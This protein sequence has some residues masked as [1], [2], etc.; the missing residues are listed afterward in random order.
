MKQNNLSIDFRLSV[1]NSNSYVFNF[2]VQHSIQTATEIMV[3][4]FDGKKSVPA[5]YIPDS[6]RLMPIGIDGY[7]TVS[8]YTLTFT[9]VSPGG[10]IEELAERVST[11][12]SALRGVSSDVEELGNEVDTINDTLPE[13]TGQVDTIVSYL[14][15][16]YM[17]RMAMGNPVIFSDGA[18][19]NFKSVSAAITYAQSGSGDPYPPGG[20]KN[21][22]RALPAS[23]VTE[24]VT[25][26]VNSNGSISTAGVSTGNAIT[27]IS[28]SYLPPGNYIV[29]G[30][31]PG[32][33]N[34]S[35]QYTIICQ[36]YSGTIFGRNNG[37][38]TPITLTENHAAFL[39]ILC[40]VGCNTDNLIFY[41]MVRHASDTDPSFAPYSNI[42]PISGVSSVTVTRTGKN[43]LDITNT[44]TATK[45]GITITFHDGIITATGEQTKPTNFVLT[46]NVLD[47]RAGDYI[48]TNSATSPG[49]WYLYNFTTSSDLANTANPAF[50]YNGTDDISFRLGPFNTP[51]EVN[52]RIMI[53]RASDADTT[54]EPYKGQSV[55]VPLTDGSNPLTVY[56]GTLDVTA[57]TL[58]VTWGNIA[59]YNGETLPGRW[60][61]DRDVYA[62]DATPTT[63]A[64][65][66]YELATPVTYQSTP[67]QL[68][69][70]PGYNAV[71]T[72]VENVSVMYLSDGSLY[73]I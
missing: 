56:G 51:G 49:R 22:I 30:C 15:S 17:Y 61:S 72:D 45:N 73:F 19:D 12:E 25:Y 2:N 70:L 66:V 62:P 68:A 35:G 10:D 16:A 23:S 5:Y 64:H 43:L 9:A 8:H 36:N 37:A 3:Q 11:I 57:G 69:A 47:L 38:D 53:R 67:V 58:T 21:L 32:G 39:R 34:S 26:T 59:S 41:P 7:W 42:R 29:S 13:L 46:T 1:V 33:G 14:S 31:P 44:G 18:A 50:T 55:T 48:V 6:Q 4:N 40:R 28:I 52:Y 24:G 54:F 63:G 20:G 71:S 65:V 60:I 27:D